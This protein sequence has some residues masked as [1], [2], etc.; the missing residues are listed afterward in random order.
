MP[1]TMARFSVLGWTGSNKLSEYR[2]RRRSANPS[3]MV[4][5]DAF[6]NEHTQAGS[7]GQVDYA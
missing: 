1:A 4:E 6:A 3:P 2:I 5:E 7:L